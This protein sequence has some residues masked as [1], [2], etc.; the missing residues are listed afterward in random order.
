M[1]ML[2]NLG[3]SMVSREEEENLQRELKRIEE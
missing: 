2:K 1:E 3:I